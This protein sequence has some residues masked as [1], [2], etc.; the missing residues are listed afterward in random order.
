MS[1]KGE[2]YGSQIMPHKVVFKSDV[3]QMLKQADGPRARFPLE[4]FLHLGVSAI[5]LGSSEAGLYFLGGK[6]QMCVGPNI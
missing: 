4:R 5:T 3:H 2:F 6:L 1:S